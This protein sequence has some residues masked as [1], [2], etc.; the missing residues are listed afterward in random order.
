MADDAKFP[1]VP[2]AAELFAWFGF[3]PTFHDG[4]V[5]SLH[6]NREGPSHFR[7]HTW[8]MTSE[9][10]SHG[11]YVLRKHVIATF[12]L[13]DICELELEGFSHQ[14]VLFDLILTK[15]PGGYKLE[16]GPSYGIGGT[17]TAGSVRIELAPG[18]PS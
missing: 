15:D 9:L 11:Y 3:W 1:D 8:E 13:E 10:D 14:N 2:G 5:L 17:I 4:E 18:I 6:L 12:F 7:V 16:F